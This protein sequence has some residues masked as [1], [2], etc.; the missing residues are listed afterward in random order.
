MWSVMRGPVV[1]G[2]AWPGFFGASLGVVRRP[3]KRRST[4]GLRVFV[5]PDVQIGAAVIRTRNAENHRGRIRHGCQGRRRHIVRRDP[6]AVRQLGLE[7][8]HQRAHPLGQDRS[9]SNTG[10]FLLP[11]ASAV[12][13]YAGRETGCLIRPGDLVG[14]R[15]GVWPCAASRRPV[16]SSVPYSDSEVDRV[17]MGAGRLLCK[18]RRSF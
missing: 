17:R 7:R 6:L 5:E 10:R 2:E 9:L 14:G 16:V 13:D 15:A 3:G 4:S 8:C 1:E 18:Q 11:A 12:G